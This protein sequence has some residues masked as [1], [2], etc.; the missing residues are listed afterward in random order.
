[1]ERYISNSGRNTYSFYSWSKESYRVSKC[2]WHRDLSPG[3]GRLTSLFGIIGLFY[4]WFVDFIRNRVEWPVVWQKRG[5]LISIM[6][7]SVFLP[8][9]RQYSKTPA[10]TLPL[11]APVIYSLGGAIYLIL[12]GSFTILLHKTAITDQKVNRV[13]KEIYTKDEK[14]LTE[15]E[16][17]KLTEQLD[18]YRAKSQLFRKL[19]IPLLIAVTIIIILVFYDLSMIYKSFV[20]EVAGAQWLENTIIDWFILFSPLTTIILF[21]SFRY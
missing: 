12:V 6:L 14:E 5:I 8:I 21:A 18:Q 1:M 3:M 20:G 17:Q 11:L 4:L 9:A 16:F 2:T 15:D 19:L 10:S 13:T 7:I